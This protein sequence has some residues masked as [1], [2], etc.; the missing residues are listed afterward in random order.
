M[1]T[2]RK[3]TPRSRSAPTV[4]TMS[5][6]LATRSLPRA[7]AYRHVNALIDKGFVEES[8]VEGE[9][10]LSVAQRFDDMEHALGKLVRT[11]S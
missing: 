2:T 11:N 1:A 7:S 4:A 5:S 10:V 3:A 8:I 9:R 6:L